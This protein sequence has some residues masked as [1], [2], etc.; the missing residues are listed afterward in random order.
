VGNT[1]DVRVRLSAEGEASVIAAFRKIQAQ[2]ETTGKIGA[3]GLDALTGAASRLAAIL[4]ALSIAAIVAAG[5]RLAKNA[6]ETADNFAKLSQKTGVSVETLSGYAHAADLAGIDTETLALA[7]GKLAKAANAAAQGGEEAKGPFHDLGIEFKNQQG[8]LRP[9]DDLLGDVADK[10]AGMPDGPRKAALAIELFGKSGDRMIPFLNEGRAGLEEMRKEAE[11]LGLVF[12]TKT[13][14]AIEQFNDN[15]GRLRGTVQGFVNEELVALLPQLSEF[16]VKVGLLNLEIKWWKLNLESAAFAAAGLFATFTHWSGD[17]ARG[18]FANAA[19]AAEEAALVEIQWNAQLSKSLGL[20]AKL[21]QQRKRTGTEPPAT[22]EAARAK[23]LDATKRLLDAQL[24]LTR[25]ELESELALVRAHNAAT[26]AE[27]QQLFK[28]GLTALEVYFGNRRAMLEFEAKKEIEILEKQAAA[29][30]ERIGQAVTQPL[31]KGQPEADRQTELLKL[32]VE[33]EKTMTEIE[34]RRLTLTGQQ[35]Q[36]AGEQRD[37]IRQLNQETLKAEAERLSAQG[38][39]F[40]AERVELEAQIA[41]VERL[42][43]ESDLE[44][45]ARLD[46]LRKAGEARIEFGKVQA[47]AQEAFAKLE[48]ARLGIEV[49]VQRGVIS[50]LE[51]QRQIALMETERLPRLREIAEAMKAGAVTD[52]QVES[53]RKFG[54]EV[55]KLAASADLAG[56][57]M[58]KLKESIQE[59]L[60]SDLANFF[61]RGV[62]EATSFGDAMRRLAASVVQS[63]REIAS[64]MLANLIIQGL[65]GA[66]LKGATSGTIGGAEF[67]SAGAAPG[68]ASGGLVRGPGSGTSDSIPIRVSTGEYITRAAVVAQPGVLPLLETLNAEGIAQFYKDLNLVMT[69]RPRPMPRARNYAR[70]GLVV[71]G[72]PGQAR[73]PA[74]A[75]LRVGLDRGLLLR[76]LHAHPDWRRV[77]VNTLNENRR[78]VKAILG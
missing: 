60:T 27:E 13:A 43:G 15:M 9:L 32:R 64:Q 57:R 22:D 7:L 54:D 49:L 56:D 19:Q 59:A 62:D 73:G 33:F 68:A 53:A 76:D 28:E 34:V 30:Q 42:K 45:I 29:I 72:E 35:A 39:R 50:E 23:A 16:I 12:D 78:A 18:F 46:V 70:G 44:F 41:A 10:F 71:D 61:S 51:G 75:E 24:A 55:E 66:F 36:L 77:I 63:L 25:T 20:L 58:K 3:R 14:L 6:L 38:Q 74:N 2:A 5:I 47:D 67:G 52:E 1:P 37:A 17:K 4:P 65:M 11:R 69:L 26:S 40:A 8:G 31:K 21:G 48:S